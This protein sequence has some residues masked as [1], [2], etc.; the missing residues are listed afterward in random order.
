MKRMF[1]SSV[2]AFVAC[3]FVGCT[4]ANPLIEDEDIVDEMVIT[5]PDE[6]TTNSGDNITTSDDSVTTSGAAPVVETPVSE[7]EPN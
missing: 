5:E 1:L 7:D 2:V 3:S 4:P 6:S